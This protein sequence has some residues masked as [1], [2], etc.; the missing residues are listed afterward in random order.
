MGHSITDFR[1]AGFTARD[2]KVEVWLQLLA[3]EVD[4]LSTPPAWLAA[5]RDHWR[6]QATLRINGCIRPELDVYLTDD[7]RVAVVHNLAQRVYDS[8]LQ[9]GE[10]VPRDFLNGLC[11]LPQREQYS[12]DMQTE[13]FL[14]YG[15]ALLKLLN[16]KM[17]GHEFA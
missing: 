10:R 8:L 17:K 16:G 1:G 14:V 4:Q 5:A 7:Q 12:Q 15:R 2:W 3:R 11:R 13:V 6:E 9:F